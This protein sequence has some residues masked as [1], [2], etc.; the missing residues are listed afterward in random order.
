VN[1]ATGLPAVEFGIALVI[2]GLT[3]TFGTALPR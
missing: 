1:D 3:P 2:G